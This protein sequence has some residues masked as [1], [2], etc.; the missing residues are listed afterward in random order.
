MQGFA[1]PQSEKSE[2]I[3]M[4]MLMKVKMVFLIGVS[5]AFLFS[6]NTSYIT[7]TPRNAGNLITACLS[8][9]KVF[10]PSRSHCIDEDFVQW[11]LLSTNAQG[12]EKWI[13][14]DR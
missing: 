1:Q 5:S 8:C 4:V 12:T 7:S 13:R 6:G 2:T 14:T 9:S 10:L 11:T 3:H